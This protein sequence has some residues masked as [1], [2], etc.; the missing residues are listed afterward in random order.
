MNTADLITK[1]FQNCCFL[2]G[3]DLSKCLRIR[4]SRG[5][6]IVLSSE[7]LWQNREVIRKLPDLLL[8]ESISMLCEQIEAMKK[9]IDM[10]SH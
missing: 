5:C 1:T 4:T 9:G 10:L 2:E 8:Y 6:T 3:D 7:R